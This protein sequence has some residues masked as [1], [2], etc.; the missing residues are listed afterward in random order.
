M[1]ATV[2]VASTFVGTPCCLAPEMCQDLPY[3][4][5]ADVWVCQQAAYD[6][7]MYEIKF[8]GIC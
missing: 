3:S 5:K 2:D 7:V 4:S 1:T 8:N 6:F